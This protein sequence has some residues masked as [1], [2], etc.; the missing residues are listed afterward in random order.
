MHL[1]YAGAR[2]RSRSRIPFFFRFLF[3][4]DSGDTGWGR[5]TRSIRG[6]L[7]Q[8]TFFHLHGRVPRTRFETRSYRSGFLPLAGREAERWFTDKRRIPPIGLAPV[9]GRDPGPRG[10]VVISTAVSRSRE[11]GV[12]FGVRPHR[13]RPVRRGQPRRG[14]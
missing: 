12:D 11:Y 14:Y 2:G 8:F 13:R 10:P 7:G 1:R 6:Q 4:A 9:G 3:R 5:A